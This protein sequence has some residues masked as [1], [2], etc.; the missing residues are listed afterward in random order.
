[1]SS[2][3]KSMVQPEI[4]IGTLGHVDNGK[5]T[6]VQALTGIWTA[7]HSEE[8]RRGIT[9]RLGYADAYFYKCSSC[10]AP[11]CYTNKE[12]CSICGSKT[13]FLRGVSFV[14]CPGHHSLM[15]TMLSGAAL[16]DGALFVIAANAKFPQAQDREHLLAAEMVGIKNIVIVQNKIDIVSKDRALDNFKDIEKFIEGK[17]IEKSPVI[18]LSAHHSVNLDLLIKTI[19][20]K[21][22][23]PKRNA[24]A[25]PAMQVLRS[26]DVN[27]PGTH[28]E[29][30]TGGVL[31]G[32][33][34][35][36]EFK[37]DDEIEIRPGIRID[38][39]GRISY[40]P[41]YTTIEDL[42]IG[43]GLV[44]KTG[45]GGLV[46][47]GTLLC[48]SITKSDGLVGSIVGREGKLPD[49]LNKLTLDIQLFER[50]V[51]T[52][53]QTP[54]DKI[55][56]NEPLVLNVGTSVT[57]GIITS[58]REDIIE[59]NLK[60]PICALINNKV[61]VSRRMGDSWRLIGFGTIK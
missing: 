54:V 38:K 51:G 34:I 12:K 22:Q 31:G 18:P 32:S 9:I 49:T 44:D 39:S 21:M 57:S 2:K 30:L 23:T 16:M 20:E 24:L 27:K 14:D 19:E 6:L 33:I 15:L 25:D 56:S 46:G 5:S 42:H 1:M 55:R 29:N 52:K 8:L 3:K 53:E 43:T 36:G 10:E 4:N 28:A 60:R 61:A 58:A 47:I 37:K 35:E 48:P 45:P 59:M 40:E 11:Q 50:A 7:R 26:F 41:L 17:S 13:D